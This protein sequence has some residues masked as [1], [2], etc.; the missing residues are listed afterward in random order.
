MKL[1][2][3][4]ITYFE[5]PSTRML[6]SLAPFMIKISLYG[7]CFRSS[8]LHQSPHLPCHAAL[9][10]STLLCALSAV[11]IRCLLRKIHRQINFGICLEKNERMIE[12]HI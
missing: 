11:N 1:N 2:L 6:T 7:V 9:Q 5:S 8:N 4:L 3:T 10:S 12:D